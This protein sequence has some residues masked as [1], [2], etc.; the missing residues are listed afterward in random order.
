M[1]A[2]LRAALADR[3]EA[4][5]R[6]YNI[7]TGQQTSLNQLLSVLQGQSSR[8]T[9]QNRPPRGIQGRG[10]TSFTGGHRPGAPL[11][12]FPSALYP[13]ICIA[14]MGGADMIPQWQASKPAPRMDQEVCRYEPAVPARVVAANASLRHSFS[15]PHPATPTPAISNVHV[16]GPR[17]WQIENS[18]RYLGSG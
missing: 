1:Q 4:L 13:G 6:V 18:L 15:A 3:S 12:G 5:R 7:G 11:P 17:K 8:R 14:G 2:N 16:H 10:H 9:T